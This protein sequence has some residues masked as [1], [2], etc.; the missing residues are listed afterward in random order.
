[1]GWEEEKEGGKV[2]ERREGEKGRGGNGRE[3]KGRG[4]RER[5]PNGC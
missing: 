4:M 2:K 5:A 1:M 3:K